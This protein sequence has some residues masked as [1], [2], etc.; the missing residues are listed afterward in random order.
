MIAGPTTNGSQ[1]AE[2]QLLQ[3]HSDYWLAAGYIQRGLK[4]LGRHIPS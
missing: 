2:T 1:L 3:I 4:A